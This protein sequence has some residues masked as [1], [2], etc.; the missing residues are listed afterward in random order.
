MTHIKCRY[1]RWICSNPQRMTHYRICGFPED[2]DGCSE[3]IGGLRQGDVLVIFNVCRHA[4]K[5]YSQF[6]GD[7]KRYKYDDIAG[8]HIAS[9][10]I[11]LERIE[12][13]EIDGKVLVGGERL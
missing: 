12:Y 8:L 9:R 7:Y 4:L 10:H 5:S 11:D 13:L 6:E 2:G 1:F 3:F